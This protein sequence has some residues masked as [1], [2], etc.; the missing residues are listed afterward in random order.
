MRTQGKRR[1]KITLGDDGELHQLLDNPASRRDAIFCVHCSA[2]NLPTAKYCNTCGAS[3]VEQKSPVV[4]DSSEDKYKNNQAQDPELPTYDP[5]KYDLVT[6]QHSANL[7]WILVVIFA[8][9][10]LLAFLPPAVSLVIILVA[11]VSVI[12]YSV[13]KVARSR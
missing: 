8:A 1:D 11:T 9:W 4:P 12:I 13:S 10:F 5:S 2:P 7:Q 6:K 3:L